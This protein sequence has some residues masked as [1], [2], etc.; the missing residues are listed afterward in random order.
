METLKI[1]HDHDNRYISVDFS[2]LYDEQADVLSKRINVWKYQF[3]F[4]I[5]TIYC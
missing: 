4:I 2:C 5:M 3:Y 1:V